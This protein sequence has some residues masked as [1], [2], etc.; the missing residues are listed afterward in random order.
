MPPCREGDDDFIHEEPISRRVSGVVTYRAQVAVDDDEEPIPPFSDV[1]VESDTINTSDNE[2]PM[3][4]P[5]QA[6]GLS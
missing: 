1:A 3:A 2:P 5:F 6:N 4:A